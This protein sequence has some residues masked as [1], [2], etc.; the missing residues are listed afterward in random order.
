MQ[1]DQWFTGSILILKAVPCRTFPLLISCHDVTCHI[2]FGTAI[3][4]LLKI[5]S[6]YHQSQNG[7][8]KILN[9][10]GTTHVILKDYT[11]IKVMF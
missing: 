2:I 5:L 10:E 6:Y 8:K 7:V 1:I 9:H 3:S 11:R 4:L